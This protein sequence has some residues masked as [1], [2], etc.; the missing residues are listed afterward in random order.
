M[1]FGQAFAAAYR[2]SLAFLIACPLLALLP[3]AFEVAQHMA[4]VHIG[5]YASI[6]AAKAAE[7]DPLRMAFG[8]AKVLSLIVPSYCVVR[9]LATRDRT[10]AV[11]IEKR[12]VR[13]FAGVV[14]FN[15]VLMAVQLFVLPQTRGVLLAAWGTGQVIT[16]L[17]AAWSV[18]APLGNAALG[19]RASV[20]IM[21]RQL[22]WTFAFLLAAVLPLMIPHY[23]LAVLAIVGPKVLLWPVLIGDALLVGWLGPL[24]IASTYVAAVRAADRAEVALMP[25][26]TGSARRLAVA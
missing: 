3:V 4:E 13:L 17:V 8:F 9:F 18:A 24:L 22:S 26:E 7:H 12:A 23:V 11:R 10:Y 1:T 6:T 25:M 21:A 15:A 2:G 19:P 20:A 5:M 14:A 16:C